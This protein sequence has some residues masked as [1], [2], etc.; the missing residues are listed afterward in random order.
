MSRRRI[1]FVSL[2]S[3]TVIGV[4]LVLVAHAMNLRNE[5]ARLASLTI[6]HARNTA[7]PVRGETVARAGGCIACHTD[8]ENGG[9]MLAGGVSFVSPF[10]TFVSPN[11]SSDP[12]AGIGGWSLEMLAFFLEIGMTP[13]GD[14]SGGHMAAVI[15]H[16]TAHLPMS[17]LK[18]IAAHLKSPSN[19][20]HR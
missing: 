18:A 6:K 3:V 19:E 16:G 13:E 20:G 4:S 5:Q 7:D 11:I 17:D 2:L 1:F 8:T 10:G 14:F 15:E 12:D 9:A